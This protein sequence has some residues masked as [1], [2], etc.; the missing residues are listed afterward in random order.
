[1]RYLLIGL[2][3]I[4]VA[5]AAVF[6]GV[7]ISHPPEPGMIVT[8]S[9]QSGAIPAVVLQPEVDKTASPLPRFEDIGRQPTKFLQLYIAY[10]LA[11]SSDVPTL[12]SH[13]DNLIHDDDP[14]FHYNIASVF[15][16][17]LIELDVMESINYIEHADIHQR[18]IYR[19]LS[20]IVINWIHHD[21]EAAI[22]YVRKIDSMQLKDMIGYR[23]I[24]DPTLDTTGMESFLDQDLGHF[25]KAIMLTAGF[26]QEDP[27]V[28]F[29]EALL[30]KGADRQLS[31]WNAA[32]RWYAEEPEAVLT[33]VLAMENTVEKKELMEM[34]I[35]HQS[36]LDP[37]AAL[38]MI[39]NY[40]PKD[41]DM[42]QDVLFSMIGGNVQQ[43]LPYVNDFVER[44]GNTYMLNHLA[45]AWSG[46]DPLAAID[47]VNTLEKQHRQAFLNGIAIGY[48]Y[49]NPDEG[50]RWAM[51]LN[52]R[53]VFDKVINL[54]PN[55]DIPLAE[56]LLKQLDDPQHYNDLLRNIS[57][58]KAR[59]D[60]ESA[61][62][63]LTKYQ[64]ETG[65]RGALSNVIDEWARHDP[66]SA[67]DT[68]EKHKED[69]NYK[70]LFSS[71][72]QR[73]VK[74][75]PVE[76]ISWIRSLPN[77]EI[78]DQ[79][80]QSV[81]RE[82]WMNDI[83]STIDLLDVTIDLLDV[84]SDEQSPY[85]RMRIAIQWLEQNS[86]DIEDIVDKLDLTEEQADQLRQEHTSSS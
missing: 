34:L 9:I 51:S 63:W 79:V 61:Y 14:F 31:M 50:V 10:H 60:P 65:Y 29:E 46:S 26:R 16:D 17:R 82:L 84:I 70:G 25:G 54:L 72:A 21:P 73:W 44:T 69:S 7:Q 86:D 56:D 78:I 83:D 6:V 59:A 67:A 66:R 62:Q 42:V 24:S 4:I 57:F 76:A 80:A 20:D 75:D 40:Y 52:N 18:R 38:E 15:L 36:H 19:F 81:V 33:R 22:E 35:R 27:E 37:I 41:I 68:L 74:R 1:M 23:L 53:E 85:V 49:N 55:F 47:Y 3:Y 71:V 12:K 2:S 64:D 58:H 13:M 30:L 8:N 39:Q 11:A 45:E 32:S 77:G 28:A 43:A 5:V 48:V